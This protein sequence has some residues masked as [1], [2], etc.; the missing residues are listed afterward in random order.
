MLYLCRIFCTEY[1]HLEYKYRLYV[2]QV[3]FFVVRRNKTIILNCCL[4]EK[5]KGLNIN[6]L[7]SLATF[8]NGINK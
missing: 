6:N 1:H 4:H 3:L 7:E 5:F 8:T 2:V